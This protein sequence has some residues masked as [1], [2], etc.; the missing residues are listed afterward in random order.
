MPASDR[1]LVGDSIPQLY[2]E[3]GWYV[4][5]SPKTK[6]GFLEEH[7]S[8]ESLLGILE[9]ENGDSACIP[10]LAGVCDQLPAIL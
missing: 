5:V 6:S 1:K 10:Q 3:L 2:P 9:P 7:V 8:K 4:L